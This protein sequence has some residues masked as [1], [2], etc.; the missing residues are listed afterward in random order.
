VPGSCSGQAKETFN[1][2]LHLPAVRYQR[3]FKRNTEIERI[4]GANSRTPELVLGDIRGQLAPAVWANSACAN[5]PR[6]SARPRPSPVSTACWSSPA[7]A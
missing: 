2:G 7:C 6:N 4:I 1:E 5:S 3:A